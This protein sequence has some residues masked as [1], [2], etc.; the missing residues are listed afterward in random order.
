MELASTQTR[1]SLEQIRSWLESVT[2]PEIP[3][4]SVVDLGIVRAVTW[5]AAEEGVCEVTVTPTYSGCPATAVIQ[6]R[7]REELEGHGLRVQLQV[8][9]SPPW[10]TNWISPQGKEKLRVFGIAPPEKSD[11]ESNNPLPVFEAPRPQPP[12]CPRCG[13]QRTTLISQFGTTLCKALYRCEECR[14]PFDFFKCH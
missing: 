6:K 12:A 4:I 13:S 9:L 2:D 1:T 5:S 10:T 8:R 3:V 7:I 11:T 14:E